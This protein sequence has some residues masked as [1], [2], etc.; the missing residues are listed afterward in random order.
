MLGC[1]ARDWERVSALGL[2]FAGFKLLWSE[3]WMVTTA[4]ASLIKL[5]VPGCFEVEGGDAVKLLLAGCG[6]EEKRLCS[7]CIPARSLASGLAGPV[8]TCR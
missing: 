4:S 3:L 7:S 2:V 8:L 5:L 1:E 6:G